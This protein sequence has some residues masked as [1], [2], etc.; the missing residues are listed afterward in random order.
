MNDP[1][2]R[3]QNAN[4]ASHHI[5]NRSQHRLPQRTYN[6][7]RFSN[8]PKPTH[9]LK[10]LN[11]YNHNKK[12]DNCWRTKLQNHRQ[13]ILANNNP[14]QNHKTHP[15]TKNLCKNHIIEDSFPDHLINEKNTTLDFVKTPI[16]FKK[17][18]THKKWTTPKKFNRPKQINQ[19]YQIENNNPSQTNYYNVLYDIDNPSNTFS[20]ESEQISVKNKKIGNSSHPNIHP[21]H[22]Y[23]KKSKHPK[24][25]KLSRKVRK[26]VNQHIIQ[27]IGNKENI[28]QTDKINMKH[29]PRN[30]SEITSK[31]SRNTSKST[32][33]SGSKSKQRKHYDSLFTGLAKSHQTKKMTT[34]PFAPASTAV[35]ASPDV[36]TQDTLLDS[37]DPLIIDPMTITLLT[38]DNDIK[39]IPI[40]DTW[41]VYKYNAPIVQFSER[42]WAKLSDND[43]HEELL[44][45]KPNDFHQ[46]VLTSDFT[47]I[48]IKPT[49]KDSE[50]E[51]I[52]KQDSK[53]L[54]STYA[55]NAG[56]PDFI[57]RIK[58]MKV[59]ELRTNLKDA[60]DELAKRRQSP[61]K[62]NKKRIKPETAI[63]FLTHET[64]DDEIKQSDIHVITKEIKAVYTDKNLFDSVE[65]D[66][67]SDDDIIEMVIDERDDMKKHVS[68]IPEDDESQEEF[69]DDVSMYTKDS[70][71]EEN[72]IFDN[73]EDEMD[74]FQVED[75][76]NEQKTQTSE[77]NSFKMTP[78]TVDD[79]IYGL[80]HSRAKDI[81]TIYALR[82]NNEE[83]KLFIEEEAITEDLYEYLLVIR[84]HLIREEVFEEFN[85]SPDTTDEEI[86]KLTHE[87]LKSFVHQIFHQN[88]KPIQHDFFSNKSDFELKLIL[89]QERD[90]LK[91]IR[92]YDSPPEQDKPPI[93]AQ[94]Y[95][96][97]GL[98]KKRQNLNGT[99]I[100]RFIPKKTL[101]TTTNQKNPKQTGDFENTNPDIVEL[102]KN[103]FYIRADIST[104]GNGTHIPT[105]VRR[106]I[107]AL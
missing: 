6:T 88:K 102:K 60:R 61:P 82:E 99:D 54:L 71:D 15:H 41:E 75:Q 43:K 107:K 67:L 100:N 13:N 44:I 17:S 55:R 47:T 36:Q 85:F 40:K 78:R 103:Q 8:N 53:Y 35:T 52:P 104:E 46:D 26:S 63:F 70:K 72:S 69:S 65:W 92:D 83:Q 14:S 19:G 31:N 30:F 23:D 24:Y 106:F 56:Y 3:Q 12:L 77:K 91:A 98:K 101:K 66:E 94:Q 50:I 81:A 38:T 27:R 48:V 73:V 18:N 89:V 25:I 84:D 79:E 93:P 64:S 59:K 95:E 57:P 96:N 62:F 28:Q 87:K 45:L 76:P 37:D 5:G 51:T 9:R 86:K 1:P 105:I 32:K 49:T 68:D 4:G 90:M 58:H 20:N 42:D 22:E 11:I 97:S 80:S 74:N 2:G 10:K 29:E 16:S 33:Y 21:L 34:L 7:D 39:A